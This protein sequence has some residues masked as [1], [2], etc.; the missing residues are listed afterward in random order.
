[1]TNKKQ[2][3]KFYV[4]QNN[5]LI[6]IVLFIIYSNEPYQISDTQL[7]KKKKAGSKARELIL[8]QQLSQTSSLKPLDP[9]KVDSA[10]VNFKNVQSH[11]AYNKPNL[12]HVSTLQ[13]IIYNF[14]IYP[15]YPFFF[16]GTHSHCLFTLQK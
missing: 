8:E 7:K 5:I 15:Y 6:C 4:T 3:L 1:M 12:Q 14:I 13:Y 10:K 9:I 11:Y 2:N 16:R